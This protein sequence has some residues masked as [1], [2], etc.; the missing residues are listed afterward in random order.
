MIDFK[1]TIWKQLAKDKA[2]KPEHFLQRAILTAIRSKTNSPKEEIVYSLLAKYFTP[3]TNKN[4]LSNGS[5]RFSSLKKALWSLAWSREKTI[6]GVE[7]SKI[8]ETPEEETQ[9]FDM[10]ESIEPSRVNRKKYVY[11]FTIQEGLT[12]E[13][14]GVQAGHAL[15]ALGVS[16]RNENIDPQS[17]YFQWIGVKNTSELLDISAKHPRIQHVKFS[18]PDMGN[19]ITSIAFRPVFADKR[20]E[21]LDY[22]LLVH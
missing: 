11:Y 8:F 7:P 2:F 22:E 4:K 14:Q 17:T 5:K 6:L 21:F 19:I 18:E 13:Q 16:L 20:R 1:T 9:Y 10:L 15:F 12:P 3:I